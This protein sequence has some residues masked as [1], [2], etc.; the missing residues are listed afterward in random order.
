MPKSQ[1]SCYTQFP[2]STQKGKPD[3]NSKA[4]LGIPEISLSD[5]RKQGYQMWRSRAR[6]KIQPKPF[7]TRLQ[8]FPLMVP[9]EKNIFRS[10][11][12]ILAKPQCSC[13]TQFPKYTNMDNQ[14]RNSKAALGIP[15]IF[16]VRLQE[17]RI[18]NVEKQSTP[19]NPT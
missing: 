14:D 10:P 7:L 1:H 2:K 6:H 18:S 3:L 11:S 12:K 13:D 8:P 15:E 17:T 5:S 19:Q 4:A 16:I 9:R